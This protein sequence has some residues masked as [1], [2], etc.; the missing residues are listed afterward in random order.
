[1][2]SIRRAEKEFSDNYA[3]FN[4]AAKPW[5]DARRFLKMKEN[6]S[7]RDALIARYEELKNEV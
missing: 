3:R 7:G 6:Y 4:R 2:K 5:R 1:M